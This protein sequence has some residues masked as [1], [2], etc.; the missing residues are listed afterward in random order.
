M[1][2]R[3]QRR[4]KRAKLGQFPSTTG[5]WASQAIFG[6]FN[7]RVIKFNVHCLPV[8]F[9]LLAW[10]ATKSAIL[11]HS[12]RKRR[13]GAKER[14]TVRTVCDEQQIK[15]ATYLSKLWTHTQTL[16]AVERQ[17]K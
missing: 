1:A 2:C 16:S 10:P 14:K 5:Y 3:E 11:N 12:K 9:Q 6:A 4:Q 13:K 7:A 8:L 17:R 15:F